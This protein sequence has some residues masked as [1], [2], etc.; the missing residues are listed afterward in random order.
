MH[1]AKVPEEGHLDREAIQRVCAILGQERGLEEMNFVIP[2]GFRNGDEGGFGG[3]VE[4]H[5]DDTEIGRLRLQK[6]KEL[7]WVRKTVVVE[8]EGYLAVEEGARHI[9]EEGWDLV[10]E[11]GSFI[12][13]KGDVDKAGNADY[14]KHEVGEK[15]VWRA[16]ARDLDYLAG[17]KTL[18]QEGDE[19]SIHDNGG[20]H[21]GTRI[22][23]ERML[24]GFGPCT[25]IE[26]A[27]DILPTSSQM[28]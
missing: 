28:R 24:K 7:D 21:K 2:A 14:E 19:V 18:L 6:I 3:Y 10:C 9:M 26:D 5:D 22:K 25:F 8:K 12:W 16:P 13:E 20:R 23:L 17:V 4:D 1:M 11:P 15:R 27:N